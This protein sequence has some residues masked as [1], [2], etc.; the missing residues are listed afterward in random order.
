MD[1]DND[2]DNDNNREKAN[3]LPKLQ[4][5]KTQSEPVVYNQDKDHLPSL[6]SPR[7]R[8]LQIQEQDMMDDMYPTK[9]PV[10][11]PRRLS[12][13]PTPDKQPV[14]GEQWPTPKNGLTISQSFDQLPMS[15]SRYRSSSVSATGCNNRADRSASVS[16]SP[17]GRV[18][19]SSPGTSTNVS[20]IT[21]SS[22]EM[23]PVGRRMTSS[24][25]VTQRP[26]LTRG[27]SVSSL[28]TTT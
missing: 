11:S 24:Q 21:R 13:G 12:G 8:S 23:S 7:I 28:P 4:L 15:Y 17:Q 9:E 14:Q 2:K 3:A 18:R 25:L 19:G 27:K 10:V 20:A 1:K 22:T 5:K 26:I 16:R 6:P